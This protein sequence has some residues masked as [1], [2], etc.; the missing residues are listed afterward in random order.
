MT[1]RKKFDV[2]T[3]QGRR[4]LA[5]P[6][7]WTGKQRRAATALWPA[8]SMK[9]RCLRAAWVWGTVPAQWCCAS[10][11]SD[12]GGELVY[13]LLRWAEVDEATPWLLFW[14]GRSD[15]NRFYIR[16]QKQETCGLIKVATDALNR[17]RLQ[18]E[19]MVL[20]EWDKKSPPFRLPTVVDE[21]KVSDSE[22]ALHLAGWPIDS[23]PVTNRAARIGSDQVQEYLRQ[24]SLA[25][26]SV[27]VKETSWFKQFQANAPL[28]AWA[29][30]LKQ[31]GDQTVSV[32]WA[33]GDLGPGNFVATPDGELLV[34]DWE[35]ASDDAPF[36]A[37]AIGFWLALRQAQVFRNHRR[38]RAKLIQEW[39]DM[40]YINLGLNLAFLVAHENMAA[41]EMLK[42]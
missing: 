29:T 41:T 9:R 11:L 4:I 30:Q 40:T 12:I 16:Y 42:G 33:H 1:T 18:H 10:E 20:N 13:S 24:E 37:D 5:C 6:S 3:C 25:G 14:P 39:P 17:S 34:Y 38:V 2:F 19:R 7:S 36:A 15:R 21:K 32:A 26:R 8:S 35:C 28:G 22:Y 23:R 31:S 27:R